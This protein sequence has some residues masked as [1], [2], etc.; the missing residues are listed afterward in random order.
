MRLADL[1]APGAKGPA[2]VAERLPKALIHR[3]VLGEHI[4]HF[5]VA[6]DRH[7]QLNAPLAVYSASQRWIATATGM[8]AEGWPIR[9]GTARWR[10]GELTVDWDAVAPIGFRW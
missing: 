10:L 1:T 3:N 6:L 4:H 9:Y 8:K 5:L 2:I 7:W